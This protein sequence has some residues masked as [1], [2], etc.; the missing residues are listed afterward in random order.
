MS[1]RY[2][3][4][5][6]DKELFMA[7]IQFKNETYINFDRYLRIGTNNKFNNNKKKSSK[8]LEKNDFWLSFI[9]IVVLSVCNGIT[10]PF[11]TFHTQI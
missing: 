1:Y 2:Y 3:G 7:K 11:F 5:R 6:Q 10:N 9:N 4:G 8:F